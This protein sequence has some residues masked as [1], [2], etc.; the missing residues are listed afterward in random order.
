MNPTITYTAK[1]KIASIE[2]PRDVKL[3]LIGKYLHISTVQD[4]FCN[5]IN[6]E[7]VQQDIEKILANYFLSSFPTRIALTR[8]LCM[9]Y[10]V[11]PYH[12][13]WY[14]YE[15]VKETLELTSQEQMIAVAKDLFPKR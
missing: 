7:T 4:K 5:Y 2:L 6:I 12:T 8:N 3:E 13:T 14:F 11:T 1:K 9:E 10:Q 15:C